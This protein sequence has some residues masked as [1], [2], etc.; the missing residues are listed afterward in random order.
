[1]TRFIVPIVIIIAAL[2]L[3]F[4]YVNP[5]YQ[6]IKGLQAQVAAYDNAL[7]NAKQ[8]EE[9]KAQLLA[10]YND[11]PQDNIEKLNKLLPDNVDNIRLILEIESIGAK[12]GMGIKDV[13]FNADATKKNQAA[14]PIEAS[15]DQT[16]LE[17][18]DYGVFDMSFSSDGTYPNFVLF[19]KDLEKSLRLVDVKGVDF[20]SSD[21]T[22]AAPSFGQSKDV[23]KYKIDIRTFWLKN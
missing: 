14:S 8:L 23:I 6:E 20:A 11:I 17:N 22:A 12:Y 19:M 13:Q 10:T 1:M 9:T 21:A 4:S 5:R 18:K 2:G 7:N 15:T 3:F 16:Q